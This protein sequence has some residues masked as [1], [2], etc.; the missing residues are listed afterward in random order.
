MITWILIVNQTTGVHKYHQSLHASME[1]ALARLHAIM[2]GEL[3]SHAVYKSSWTTTELETT[4]RACFNAGWEI[5][6]ATSS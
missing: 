3:Q 4:F 1:Q 2:A 5:L 6:K